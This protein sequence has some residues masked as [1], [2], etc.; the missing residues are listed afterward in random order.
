MTDS[1]QVMDRLTWDDND[2][3]IRHEWLESWS[4]SNANYF[5][6]KTLAYLISDGSGALL[7][8][9]VNSPE[10]KIAVLMPWAFG[11]LIIRTDDD[12][13]KLA[14]EF[15]TKEQE[16]HELL[17]STQKKRD[18]LNK[19]IRDYEKTLKEKCNDFLA[20]K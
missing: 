10:Y 19:K 1:E 20:T 8:R 4:P 17:A 5:S 6:R 11:Q 12:L 3:V 2:I 9:Q 7:F 16:T 14:K 13:S 18:L 15:A